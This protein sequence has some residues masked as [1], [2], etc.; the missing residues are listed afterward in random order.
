MTPLTG[1]RDHRLDGKDRVVIPAHFASRIHTESEGRLFLVP[2]PTAPCLQAHPAAFFQRIAD[3][4]VPDPLGEDDRR[5]RHFFEGAEP[6]EMKGPGRITLPKRFLDYFP[7]RV[8]RVAG[9]NTY[10]ELWDPEEWEQDRAAAA[11]PLPKPRAQGE[12]S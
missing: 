1:F 4:L 8:V 3:Q 6:V 7:S 5:R 2:S 10:L 12:S 9:L 11:G